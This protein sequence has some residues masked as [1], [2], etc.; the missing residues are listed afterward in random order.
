MR[1]FSFHF[2]FLKKSMSVETCFRGESD[3]GWS[4]SHRPRLHPIQDC[5]GF[6][7]PPPIFPSPHGRQKKLDPFEIS[8]EISIAFGISI[9]LNPLPLAGAAPRRQSTSIISLTT[10]RRRTMGEEISPDSGSFKNIRNSGCS[11]SLGTKKCVLCLCVRA[12]VC[13]LWTAAA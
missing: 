12:C 11:C 8:F 9:A 10:A 3:E 5:F 2:F 7:P 1:V 13:V 4:S 6:D